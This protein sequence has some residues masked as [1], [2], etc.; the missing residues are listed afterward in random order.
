MADQLSEQTHQMITQLARRGND[1]ANSGDYLGAK[2]VYWKA[3]DLLPDP[4]TN[5]EATTWILGSIGDMWFLL[6]D[7]DKAYQ[8]FS[9]AVRCPGGIGN[10]FIHLRLGEI[11]FEKGEQA[12]A[13]DELTRAYAIGGPEAFAKEDPKYF[14]LLKK[15]LRPPA[16]RNEL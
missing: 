14:A 6:G 5:W 2:E 11:A 7:F 9:D 15:H 12:R 16:G 1:L 10:P 4:K 3:F 8:A 13:L